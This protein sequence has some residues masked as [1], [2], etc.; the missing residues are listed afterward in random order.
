MRVAFLVSSVLAVTLPAFI[1][2]WAADLNFEDRVRAQ[3]AI[4]RV[5]YAHQIGATLPFEQAVPRT[6]LG[7][8]RSHFAP[9]TK[10][11]TEQLLSPG[12]RP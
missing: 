5:Y 1:P 8:D 7:L 6:L 2:A 11:K 10:T 9:Y 3:E 12:D 4:E